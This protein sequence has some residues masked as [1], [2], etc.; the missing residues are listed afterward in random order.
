MENAMYLVTISPAFEVA[1]PPSVCERLD[2]RPGQ[3][4]QVIAYENRMEFIPLRPPR[5]MRGF[6][7]GM[8][9]DFERDAEWGENGRPLGLGE[10]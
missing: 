6:L 9:T 5:E 8:S 10:R 3:Q 2:L 4:V 1:I 7:K